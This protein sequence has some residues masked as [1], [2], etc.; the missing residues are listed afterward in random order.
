MH[1]KREALEH[2]EQ[3]THEAREHNEHDACRARYL[4]DS[5]NISGQLLITKNMPLESLLAFDF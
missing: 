2:V 3:E 5:I 4:T 1:K